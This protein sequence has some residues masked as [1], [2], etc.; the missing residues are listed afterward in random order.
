MYQNLPHEYQQVSFTSWGVSNGL[1]GKNYHV[2]LTLIYA[3]KL[4]S[5]N[6]SP[7]SCKIGKN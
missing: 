1:E 2:K 7:L 5:F 4:T 3:G 6:T